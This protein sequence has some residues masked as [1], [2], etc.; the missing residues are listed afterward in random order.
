MPERLPTL[1]RLVKTLLEFR[2]AHQFHDVRWPIVAKL[3]AA[4]L[5][6]DH[7]G[8]LAESAK[9]HRPR[10]GDQRRPRL[11]QRHA[12]LESRN[13]R[14]TLALLIFVECYRPIRNAPV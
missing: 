10:R 14:Y 3:N 1:E 6:G 11:H 13:W 7:P 2:A 9:A 8:P 5:P 12:R 4:H